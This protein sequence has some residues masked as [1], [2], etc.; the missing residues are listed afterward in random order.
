VV[1]GVEGSIPS[2][3]PI[4]ITIDLVTIKGVGGVAQW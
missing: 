1:L 4:S 2:L 3:R